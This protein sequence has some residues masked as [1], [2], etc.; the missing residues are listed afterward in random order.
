M[1]KIFT[2]LTPYS[3]AVSLLYLFGFWGTFNVNILEYIALTDVV[4]NAM[5]PLLYSSAFVL[6]GFTIASIMTSPM[7]TNMPSGGG[8]HLPEAKYFIW[9][10]RVITLLTLL[11]ALY[12]VFF[13]VGRTRWLNIA[14]L[15][16]TPI[17]VVIG[18]APMAE[19]YI[20]HKRLRILVVCSLTFILL[21]SFGWGA[22]DAE[23]AKNDDQ[24]LKINGII[25]KHSYVGRAGDY[26]FLWSKKAN[27]IVI[28]YKSDIKSIERSVPKEKPIYGLFNG[29]KESGDSEI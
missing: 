29:D 16:M 25:S 23:K 24:S 5:L 20:A 2:F 19:K 22:F 3:L 10:F 4:K 26:L 13:D 18:D 7:Q 27:S 21:C 6:I 1:Q 15:L 28:K 17:F 14:L 11:G 12:F 9:I 8:A